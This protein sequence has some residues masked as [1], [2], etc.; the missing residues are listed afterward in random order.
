MNCYHIII[1][2]SRYQNN[3]K[4]G[5]KSKASKWVCCTVNSLSIDKSLLSL[6]YKEIVGESRL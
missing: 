5:L 1:S 4:R 3:N 6:L 2:M